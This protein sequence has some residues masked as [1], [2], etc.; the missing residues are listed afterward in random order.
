MSLVNGTVGKSKNYLRIITAFTNANPK[1]LVEIE[2]FS[3]L[4]SKG[5]GCCASC[6]S[7]KPSNS[8]KL[9]YSVEEWIRE[10]GQLEA[11]RF[12][13]TID[14]MINDIELKKSQ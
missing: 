1:Y 11:E 8:V 12:A 3:K 7:C 2:L 6:F 4:P 10:D 14:K 9:E 5:K 13:C